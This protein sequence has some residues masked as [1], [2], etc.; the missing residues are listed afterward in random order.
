MDS[1]NEVCI[2]LDSH[3]EVYSIVESDGVQGTGG[4]KNEMGYV[5]C[6][7]N[8]QGFGQTE[9]DKGRVDDALNCKRAYMPMGGISTLNGISYPKYTPSNIAGSQEMESS[10][11]LPGTGC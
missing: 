2:V 8:V 11:N 6:G 7:V 5:K 10:S 9:V 4:E 1:D 3:I